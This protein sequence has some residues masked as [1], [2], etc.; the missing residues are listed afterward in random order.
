MVV[1]SLNEARKSLYKGIDLIK[2]M[3]IR[4]KILPYIYKNWNKMFINFL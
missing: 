1:L 2:L 3:I 4:E